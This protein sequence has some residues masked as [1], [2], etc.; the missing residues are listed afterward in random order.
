MNRFQMRSVKYDGSR[1]YDLAISL[2]AR[3]DGLL[4]CHMPL[5]TPF[6][7]YRRNLR[8][9]MNY[10]AIG[11]IWLE[12]WYGIWADARADGSLIMYYG[13]IQLP[14]R[15]AGDTLTIVDLDL[16]V[17]VQPDLSHYVDD[18]DEFEAHV[19]AM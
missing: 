14:A 1:N 2:I 15:L 5:G 16:D 8:F 10:Q 17:K 12:R 7:H 11:F 3:E 9:E 4:I 19:A 18:V 13:N 6:V